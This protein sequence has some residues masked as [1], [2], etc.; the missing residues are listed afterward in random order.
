MDEKLKKK[1]FGQYY[2]KYNPFS[3]LF[4]K[5]WF[6]QIP[7]ESK[8]I[9]L[10]PFAGANNI[11]KLMDETGISN[12]LIWKCY[13]LYPSNDS[14]NTF[15]KFKIEKRDTI[16]DFP[17]GYDL[18]I[19]NPPYLA[20][21]KIKDLDINFDRKYNDLY[22]HAL[23]LMLENCSY[24]AAIIPESFVTSNKFIDRLYGI[25]SLEFKMFDDT[26]VPVCLALF[27]KEKTKKKRIYRSN[28]YIGDLSELKKIQL[29]YTDSKI[30]KNIR[31]NDPKGN[32]G[33][34]AIDNTVTDSIRFLIG[35]EINK[36]IKV[37]SRSITKISGIKFEK[38]ESLENFIK[39]LNEEVK[40]YRKETKDVFLTSFKGLRKDNKYRRRMDFLTARK[41]IQKVYIEN[42]KGL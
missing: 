34:I 1:K 42:M 32:I 8:K 36:E 23:D 15:N 9:I 19:T 12:N 30:I 41:I 2:T 13:D 6:N 29:K 22:L 21:N 4:F 27:N 31:F 39:K 11:L 35:D 38:K 37:S 16:K 17:K 5:K 14:E 26:E 25:I 3:N 33:F 28:K 10:E 40:Q 20:K 7:E 24:V 18:V